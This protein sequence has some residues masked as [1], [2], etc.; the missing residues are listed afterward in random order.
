MH[1]SEKRFLPSSEKT[2]DITLS[3]NVGKWKIKWRKI[4]EKINL[5]LNRPGQAPRAPGI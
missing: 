1:V 3:L 2:G 4:Q 5:T